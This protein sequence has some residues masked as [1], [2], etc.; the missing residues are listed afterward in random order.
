[1]NANLLDFLNWRRISGLK[2]RRLHKGARTTKRPAPLVPGRLDDKMNVP[3]LPSCMRPQADVNLVCSGESLYG[4]GYP[5]HEGTN[6]LSFRCGEIAD[7]E[8]VAE[9]FDDQ[10]PYSQRSGA[11]LATTPARHSVQI[12]S[13]R[14]ANRQ[15]VRRDRP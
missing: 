5:L 1:M 6:F 14:S 3:W 9:G 12:A 2:H 15:G 11:V 4:V 7:M 10:G 13:A 8:T